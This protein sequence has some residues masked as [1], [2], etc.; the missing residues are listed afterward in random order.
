MKSQAGFTLIEL[1]IAVAIVS[2][3][4]SIALPAYQDYTIRARVSEAILL[5]SQSKATVAENIF[6]NG[7]I[8]AAGTCKGVDNTPPATSNV[9]TLTCTD[10]TGVITAVTTR[11]AGN[12]SLMYTPT[13]ASGAAGVAWMCMVLA[14]E[15]KHVPSECR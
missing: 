15:P 11:S 5:A 6:N 12:V 8:I 4:A 7:S 14:G 10:T 1:M 2:I 13:V 3:L 9:A